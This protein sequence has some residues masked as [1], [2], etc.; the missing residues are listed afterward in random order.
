MAPQRRFLRSHFMMGRRS[1][2]RYSGTLIEFFEDELVVDRLRE[3]DR[4]KKIAGIGESD[5]GSSSVPW[6]LNDIRP[7]D[8]VALSVTFD[9][10]T[11]NR[12]STLLGRR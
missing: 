7:A 6:V 11:N 12:R 4:K 2:L 3:S 8:G 5:L 10:F 9:R 1:D